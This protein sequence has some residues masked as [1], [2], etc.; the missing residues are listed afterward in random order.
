MVF[1]SNRHGSCL[2]LQMRLAR[3]I[4]QRFID[5]WRA[6]K[7]TP[8]APRDLSTELRPQLDELG[9]RQMQIIYLAMPEFQRKDFHT[10]Y[11]G[12][13]DSIARWGVDER[14]IS[15]LF[16]ALSRLRTTPIP[17]L[18]RIAASRILRIGTTGDYAPFT[19]ESKG[20]LIGADVAAAISLAAYS[21]P[22]LNSFERVG[23]R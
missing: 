4:Q 8:L 6:A 3:E 20:V 2:R 15:A 14:D 10:Y 22:S 21:M 9:T 19:L 18:K 1:P 11:A 13:V 7:V 23:L 5:Q 16:D 17:A 12:S